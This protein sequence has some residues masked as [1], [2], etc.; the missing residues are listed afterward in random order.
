MERIMKYINRVYRASVIDREIMFSGLGLGGQQLSYIL[1]ICRNPGISQDKIAK[2]LYV[3]KSSVTRNLIQMEK[4]G[5]IERRVCEQDKRLKR[6]FPSEKAIE[7]YPKVI[8]YL[9]KWNEA[10]VKGLNYNHD[11][12]VNLLSHLAKNATEQVN[13]KEEVSRFIEFEG[14]HIA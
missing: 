5:Y 4:N 8:D 1:L 2:R 11:D 9:D 3:N 12:V 7:I 6:I 10:I 14:D 13:K